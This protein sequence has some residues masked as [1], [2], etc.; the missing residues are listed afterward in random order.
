MQA[1]QTRLWLLYVAR[2]LSVLVNGEQTVVIPTIRECVQ[3]I[4]G[5]G[6]AEEFRKLA[7]ALQAE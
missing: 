4:S 7:L 2:A 6:P 1:L 5:A 3:L